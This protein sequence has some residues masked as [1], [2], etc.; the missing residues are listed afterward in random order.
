[1]PVQA[2][3]VLGVQTHAG[4]VGRA[5]DGLDLGVAVA[6]DQVEAEQLDWA[7]LLLLVA[8]HVVVLG[9]AGLGGF[10]LTARTL[11]AARTLW[12]GVNI[13]QPIVDQK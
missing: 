10:R 5:V 7:G 2:E 4:L 8:Q 3:V 13:V 9:H 6:V 12:S 1:M 11:L